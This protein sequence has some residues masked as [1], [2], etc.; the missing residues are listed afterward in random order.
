VGVDLRPGWNEPAG[1]RSSTSV[2]GI[3]SLN[4]FVSYT[5]TNS[6]SINGQSA[7]SMPVKTGDRVTLKVTTAGPEIDK[8]A[9]TNNKEITAMLRYRINTGSTSPGTLPPLVGAIELDYD[10]KESELLPSYDQRDLPTIIVPA[11]IPRNQ[12]G[13]NYA[14]TQP[15]PAVRYKEPF[16]LASIHLKT[17][18]DSRFPS[19]GWIHNAPWNLYSTA[20]LDQT[21]SPEHHQY[22]LGWEPMTDWKSSPTIEIDPRDRGFGGS[23]LFSQTGQNY[24]VFA[25]IPLAPPLSLGQ[26]SHAPINAGGQQPLQTHLGANSLPPPPPAPPPRPPTPPARTHPP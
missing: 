7:R 3:S 6:G 18:R 22:E 24:A 17:A 15:P 19:R 11:G 12:Q 4:T 10:R 26:L 16:F 1:E 25:S 8:F 21:E 5:G 9:E 13:D 23:G 14:G 20:G 2:G